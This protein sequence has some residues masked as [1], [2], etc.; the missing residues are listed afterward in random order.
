M[1]TG[2]TQYATQYSKGMGMYSYVDTSKSQTLKKATLFLNE[3]S[4]IQ[5]LHLIMT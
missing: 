3:T 2:T 1:N 5:D 4:Y